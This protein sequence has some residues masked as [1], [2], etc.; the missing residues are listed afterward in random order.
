MTIGTIKVLKN[1]YGFISVDGQKKDVF[2]HRSDL[3]N[4]L[5]FHSLEE[6]VEVEFEE[7]HGKKGPK[8]VKV[9]LR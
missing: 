3:I 1:G 4:G 8:A 5:A 9:S 2:F 6:G 7:A